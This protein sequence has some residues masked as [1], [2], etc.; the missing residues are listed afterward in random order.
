MKMPVTIRSKQSPAEWNKIVAELQEWLKAK[1]YEI[2]F[3]DESVKYANADYIDNWMFKHYTKDGK[4]DCTLENYQKCIAALK[5]KDLLVFKVSPQKKERANGPDWLGEAEAKRDLLEKTRSAADTVK[6]NEYHKQCLRLINEPPGNTHSARF[7]AK[8]DLQ[9]KFNELQSR[10]D[11][12][13]ASAQKAWLAME[14]YFKVV[15]SKIRPHVSSI[16]SI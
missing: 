13:V 12:T 1:G 9:N 2:D 16:S 3:D 15:T 8:E 7:L 4:T 6:R 5:Q 11:G 10:D 14:E